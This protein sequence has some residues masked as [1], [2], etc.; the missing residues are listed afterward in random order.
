[1]K[2]AGRDFRLFRGVKKARF[3]FAEFG[4][5]WK[6]AIPNPAIS[7]VW[8]GV[9]TKWGK[10]CGQKIERNVKKFSVFLGYNILRSK[11]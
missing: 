10:V 8:Y 9:L 6:E 3:L 4:S 5:V 11:P 1:L 7:G 2:K